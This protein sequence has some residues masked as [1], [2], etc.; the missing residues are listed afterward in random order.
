MS[1]AARILAVSTLLAACSAPREEP[2]TLVVETP[3]T[4]AAPAD[5]KEPV[6]PAAQ[7]P[8]AVP[9]HPAEAPAWTRG[10][11]L[12]SNG[13]TYVL[14]VAP[15]P[16]SLPDNEPFQL[17][18]WVADSRRPNVVA[19]D[20]ALAVDAAMPEHGHGMNRTPRITRGDDGRFVVEGM[21]FHMTGHW[22]LY[23]DVTRGAVTER[24]QCDIVLE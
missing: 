21:L 11:A 19:R 16:P 9:A 13:S 4:P 5:P 22:E 10:H 2:A 20:V 24:A 1:R 18:V 3:R 12:E 17:E 23:L 14:H 7:E 6:T 8:A 15:P